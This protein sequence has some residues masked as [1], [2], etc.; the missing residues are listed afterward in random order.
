MADDFDE[1]RDAAASVLE[2]IE[3]VKTAR[4]DKAKDDEERLASANGLVQRLTS[5]AE[6]MAKVDPA[7]WTIIVRRLYM[8]RDQPML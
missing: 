7:Q 2:A 1:L 3:R 6:A 5:Y 4:A 8:D